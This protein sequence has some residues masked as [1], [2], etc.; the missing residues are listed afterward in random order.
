MPLQAAASQRCSPLH[1]LRTH[2][3]AA[4]CAAAGSTAAPWQ[5]HF[6]SGSPVRRQTQAAT[7]RWTATWIYC[8]D[9]CR[10]GDWSKSRHACTAGP[11]QVLIKAHHLDQPSLLK[12]VAKDTATSPNGSADAATCL[13]P[14]HPKQQNPVPCTHAA[15]VPSTLSPNPLNPATLCSACRLPRP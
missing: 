7:T 13:C 15:T 3:S 11:A 4:K 2:S 14:P 8:I 1:E 12:A 6:T 10:C 5:T 9:L